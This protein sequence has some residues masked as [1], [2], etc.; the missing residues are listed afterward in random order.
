MRRGVLG[1]VCGVIGVSMG[2][3]ASSV[4]QS[5]GDGAALVDS[6]IELSPGGA[7]SAAPTTATSQPIGSGADAPGVLDADGRVIPASFVL[8]GALTEWG[9]LPDPP[10]LPA[11]NATAVGTPKAGSAP[12]EKKPARRRPPASSKLVIALDS[13]RVV[14][15]GELG[16]NLK[17]GAWIAIRSESPA[18]PPVGEWQRGGGAREFQCETD[19]SSGDPLD[20]ARKAACEAMLEALARWNRDYHARFTRLYRIDASGVSVLQ[21]GVSTPLAGAT[22]AFRRGSASSTFEVSFPAA[23]LPRLAQ[24]P[25]GYL[26]VAAAD[27]SPDKEPEIP[28]EQFEAASLDPPVTFEPN[29]ELR[30]L[31]YAQHETTMWF[32]FRPPLSYHPGRP[33]EIE[34]VGHP[35]SF[36]TS[37]LV[38]HNEPLFEVAGKRGDVEILFVNGAMSFALVRKAGKLG[39]PIELSDSPQV[40]VE[41]DGMLHV[42]GESHSTATDTWTESVDYS[43]AAVDKDGNVSSIEVRRPEALMRTP[44]DSITPFHDATWSSFG[45]RGRAK[46]WSE[47]GRATS[48]KTRELK[49]T[50]SARE[51]AYVGTLR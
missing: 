40:V 35:G 14:L 16:G 24:A 20:E 28:A 3:S 30:N 21:G 7:A 45:G 37:H 19:P 44:F 2:C 34:S 10:Q 27:A 49:Y 15:A 17:N 11:E 43:V 46:Q 32:W 9:P 23:E 5:S 41:R 38:I 47:D 13:Q 51:K 12:A 39:E 18:L 25:L 42:I 33:H 50:W 29:G 8:D 4:G 26:E 1:C 48:T 36:D 22:H 6:P 31:V